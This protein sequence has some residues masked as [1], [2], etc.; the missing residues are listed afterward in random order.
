MSFHQLGGVGTPPAKMPE[1]TE[2]SPDCAALEEERRRF[3]SR[4]RH[5]LIGPINTMSGF[6]ELLMEERV[7]PLNQTQRKYLTNMQLAVGRALEL[8]EAT[9]RQEPQ[10]EPAAISRAASHE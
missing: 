5:D 9:R 8:I 6:L 3:V 7:G 10:P 1:S 4:L 2:I